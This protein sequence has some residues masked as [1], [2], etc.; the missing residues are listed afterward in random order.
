MSLRLQ[1]IHWA[2]P[3][4]CPVIRGSKESVS[5]SNNDSG[6]PLWRK[7]WAYMWPPGW[8]V[9]DTRCQVTPP[10][11]LLC[12]LPVPHRPWSDIS[13]DFVTGLPPSEGN[14][15]ILIVVDRVSKMVTK[16]M[17]NVMLG[18]VFRLHGFPKDVVSHRGLQFA[19]RFWKALCSLQPWRRRSTA[20]QSR[21]SFVSAAGSGL[22]PVN[23]LFEVLPDLRGQR[24]VGGSRLF[25]TDLGR[26]CG[27]SERISP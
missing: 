7:R 8:C 21:L 11:G 22:G 16:E 12:P 25:P 10:A 18:Y 27:C 17:A 23:F 19:S 3:P 4:S 26:W 15:T 2:S 14:T 5:K 13:L 1:V 6:V 24:I 20:H 9:P